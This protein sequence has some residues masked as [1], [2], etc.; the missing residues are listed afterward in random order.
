LIK[1]GDTG[2]LVPIGDVD[3]MASNILRLL[4]NA[5]ERMRLGQLAQNY[6]AANFSLERMVDETERIYGA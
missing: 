4:M 3:A 5:D 2:L 1:E 6:A